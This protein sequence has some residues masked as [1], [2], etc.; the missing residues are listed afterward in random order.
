M[1]SESKNKKCAAYH[2][3]VV[4]NKGKAYIFNNLRFIVNGFARTGICGA[5]NG[6]TSDKELD[7]SLQDMDS[8]YNLLM[9]TLL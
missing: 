9:K 7:D 5:L 4:H 8:D 1:I 6:F 2:C 3:W